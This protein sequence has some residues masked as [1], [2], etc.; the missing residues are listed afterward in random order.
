MRAE[1]LLLLVSFILPPVWAL[2]QCIR[3][4][5]TGE[6]LVPVARGPGDSLPCWPGLGLGQSQ[7]PGSQDG[8]GLQGRLRAPDSQRLSSQAEAPVSSSS[9]FQSHRVFPVP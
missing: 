7:N 4:E 8:A 6:H 5:W 2:E 1:R 9:A 3:S